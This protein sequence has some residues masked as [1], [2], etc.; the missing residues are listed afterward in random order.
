[1]F[2]AFMQINRLDETSHPCQLGLAIPPRI[3][4]MISLMYMVMV[5]ATDIGQ[6]RRVRRNISRC[7]R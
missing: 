3:G 5:T 4:T 6:K 7:D 2:D 1:M